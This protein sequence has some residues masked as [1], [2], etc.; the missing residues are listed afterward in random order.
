[1]QSLNNIIEDI[2]KRE[3]IGIEEIPRIDLYMDQ[4]LSLFDAYFPYDNDE[5]RITKTMINNYAKGGIIKPATKKKYNK[6]HILMLII[7]CILKRN[8]SL[9]DIKTLLSNCKNETQIEKSYKEFLLNKQEMNI[10]VKEKLNEIIAAFGTD[11]SID[12]ANK[13]NMVLILSYYS[14]LLSEAARNLINE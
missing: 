12:T 5:Q 13:L 10:R 3:E 6:E 8:M 14:N 4:V 9:A 1:M 7:V 2:M 11:S